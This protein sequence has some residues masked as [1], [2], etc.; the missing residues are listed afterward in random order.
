MCDVCRLVDAKQKRSNISPAGAVKAFARLAH[1]R[2]PKYSDN[3]CVTPS[4]ISVYIFAQFASNAMQK[5][6]KTW[7]PA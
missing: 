6:I 7:R 1:I 4:S 3:R 5:K 2:A